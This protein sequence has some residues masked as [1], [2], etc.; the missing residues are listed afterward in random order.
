MEDEF[1]G[2]DRIWSCCCPRCPE[3]IRACVGMY[4]G[5]IK[6]CGWYRGVRLGRGELG[7]VVFC[8]HE[9]EDL[10]NRIRWVTLPTEITIDVDLDFF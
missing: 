3:D 1:Y 5:V 7:D 10:K 6:Q 9:R 4:R 2:A 8:N